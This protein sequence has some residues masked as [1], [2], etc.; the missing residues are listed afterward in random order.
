MGGRKRATVTTKN[1]SIPKK[2]CIKSRAGGEWAPPESANNVGNSTFAVENFFP[3]KK[4]QGV[5]KT[6]AGKYDVL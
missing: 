4:N 2:P 6:A 3:T 1:V 5:A